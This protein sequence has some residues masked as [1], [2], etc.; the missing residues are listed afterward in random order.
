MNRRK[1]LK[2][3]AAFSGAA[4]LAA[5]V[6]E[7]AFFS[8]A[9]K[10]SGI[11]KHGIAS[12]DPLQDRVILWTRITKESHDQSPLIGYE[13]FIAEDPSLLQIVHQGQGV[14]DITRDFTVKIDV[15]QLLPGK[16]YYYL[17]R[18]G[19]HYSPIGRTRTLP[20]GHTDHL[21]IAVTSC[22]S[23]PHGHF[24][25]YRAI[26]NHQDLDVVL[27]LGDYIYEYANGEYGDGTD[28]SRI[29][30]P[31]RE[32]V[33][34]NDYRLRHSQYKQD[35][36]L[37]HLHQQHA[38]INIWDDHEITNDS[39]YAGA[40]NHNPDQ[41]EGHWFDR[42]ASAVQAYMEW[43]PI[44]ENP[45]DREIIYRQFR[46]GNLI[47]LFMLDTRLY[48]RNRQSVDLVT[49]NDTKRTLLGWDQ[50]IWLHKGLST[51]QAKDTRWRILG[52]QVMMAQL[53]SNELPFN[54]DQWDGYPETR[55]RLYQHIKTNDINNFVVLTGDIH[56]SWASDLATNP[57]LLWEYN[58]ANGEGALGVEFVTPSV[59]SPSL[60]NPQ[61]ANFAA[62]A[63]NA[64]TTHIKWI[65]LYHKGFMLLDITPERI[66]SEWH[67]LETIRE[68]NAKT[69]INKIFQIKDQQNC[70]TPANTPSLSKDN[71]APFAPA[72]DPNFLPII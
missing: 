60:D 26:A 5:C 41:G 1:F 14:T 69:A 68:V 49:I 55:R 25:A 33:S 62:N 34:L 6:P 40:E 8:G 30:F 7:T 18:S 72:Y 4:G 35:L 56:S 53:P 20:E 32:T 58:P 48:G 67:H 9:P 64:L 59:T 15:D 19:N 13:W 47:D 66:Q 57:L 31:D 3:S 37:Q 10:S 71:A 27:H 61:L 54:P 65:D 51:S 42:K 63:L 12:G 39:A 46:F 24:N 21:R 2:L 50:E 70:L 23:Y 29:P 16:T 45:K 36:D 28:L 22:A 52:Q 38:V 17:F 44:R 43:M 11:F